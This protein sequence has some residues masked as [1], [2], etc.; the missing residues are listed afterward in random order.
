MASLKTPANPTQ[1]LRHVAALQTVAATSQLSV[2][3]T[4][5]L[6]PLRE[7]GVGEAETPISAC[8]HQADAHPAPPLIP[9][10]EGMTGGDEPDA[11]PA[12]PLMLIPPLR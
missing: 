6:T 5:A 7:R 2:E 11:H 10:Q 9:Q 4:Q 12:P 1:I 8:A 3:H